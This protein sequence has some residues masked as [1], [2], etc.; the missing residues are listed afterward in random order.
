MQNQFE[1][2]LFE[3]EEQITE[4][5]S[6]IPLNSKSLV[7]EII[8]LEDQVKELSQSMYSN[9]TPYETTRISRH[10]KRPTTQDILNEL[11]EQ[12]IQLR[13]DRNF[14][15]D[16]SIIAGLA[17]IGS[18]KTVVVGHQKGKCTKDNVRCNFGMPKP[19]GYRKA[20]RVFAL[21]EKFSLPVITFINT[22]GAFPGIDAEERGQSE[23]IGQTVIAMAKL[24]VPVISFIIGEGGSGGALAIGVGNR[25]HMLEYATYS[26]I[27][28]EGCA[29]ILMKDPTK[30]PTMAN[31]LKLTAKCALSNGIID[32]IIPESIGG[33]HQDYPKL[34]KSIKKVICEDL[35]ELTKWK[36]EDLREVRMT[37]FLTMG[38]WKEDGFTNLRSH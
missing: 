14:Y 24:T 28:P 34:V 31:S 26:V 20:Q 18:F 29:A 35:N 33:C 23:A 10:P 22:P 3:L 19:E 4:L 8:K 12:F 21:A 7:K 30:A 27:S 16:P 36:R 37:K 1:Q 5:K 9:L 6:A 32:S 17:E 15:D 13:G 38:R 2:T 25:V 11:S